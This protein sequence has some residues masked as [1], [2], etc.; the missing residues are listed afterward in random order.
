MHME[1][2][3]TVRSYEEVMGPD[4]PARLAEL[5]ATEPVCRVTLPTG[6]EAWLVTRYEDVETVLTDP[7][8]SREQRHA[9]STGAGGA[10]LPEE[11]VVVT[12]RTLQM[13]GP[14]HASLRRLVAKAFTARR[15]EEL[16]PRIREITDDL[17]DAMSAGGRPADLVAGLASP[18]PIQVI[19]ELLGLPVEDRDRFRRWSDATVSVNG[20]GARE[21]SDAWSG[22][23]G[24]LTDAI[25]RKR[26]HP[27]ADLV[28]AL[29]AARDQEDRLTETELLFLAIGVL[30][31]GNETTVHAIGLSVWR[32]LQHPEHWE[33]ARRDRSLVRHA[34]EE[35]L[36]YQ[37]IGAVGRRRFCVEDLSLGGVS[38]RQGDV[39][40]LAVRSANRDVACVAD[41][42][43]FDATRRRNPHLTFGQGP[44]YCIGA[45]LAR[46][47][48]QVV[49]ERLL[50]RFPALHVAVP[51]DQLRWTAGTMVTGFEELPVS[52]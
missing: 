23:I 12:D 34:V 2:S 50:E 15:V 44:H 14:D 47:E 36:R 30:I 37:P 41:P 48:L 22:L 46:V 43:R 11:F 6:E 3:T 13:D 32:L 45:A 40:L 21:V 25:A 17:L 27:A 20:H 4:W 39:V 5:R 10:T 31:G 16:R 9:G 52:W 49:L 24:Y 26:E 1:A 33:A 42:E 28:S 35:L 51:A 29:I 19:C 8:F 18:L 7:R 38:I